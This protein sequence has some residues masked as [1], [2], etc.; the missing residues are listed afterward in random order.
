MV[1]SAI[2]VIIILIIIFLLPLP[3]IR[4]IIITDIHTSTNIINPPIDP[5]TPEPSF[6][7]PPAYSSTA[8]AAVPRPFTPPQ[9]PSQFSSASAPMTATAT[10][11]PTTN[12]TTATTTTTA[13]AVP[14]QYYRDENGGMIFQENVDF[15]GYQRWRQHQH[16]PFHV[17]TVVDGDS[18][19]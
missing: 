17:E 3:S 8:A 13:P 1:A 16:Q 10:T 6:F 12:I 7:S 11:P 15:C 9:Y 4:I 18:D 19:L 14:P 5:I 2:Q